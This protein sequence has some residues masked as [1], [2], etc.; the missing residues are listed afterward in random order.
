MAEAV[1]V[2]MVEVVVMECGTNRRDRYVGGDVVSV[3]V[4]AVLRLK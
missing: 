2:V 1:V 3:V 4:V